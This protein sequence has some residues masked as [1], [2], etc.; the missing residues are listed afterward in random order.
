MDEAELSLSGLKILVDRVVENA[1]RNHRDPDK[2]KVGVRVFN[3]NTVGGTP[4][5]SVT[6]VQMG[7]DW[8]ANRCIIVPTTELI[9]RPI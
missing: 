4:M 9:K 5:V 2:I 1:N 6:T 8:D 3:P 7:F